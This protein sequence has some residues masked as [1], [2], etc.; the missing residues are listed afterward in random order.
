MKIF[1][2]A[3]LAAAVTAIKLGE[4]ELPDDLAEDLKADLGITDADLE[5]LEKLPPKDKKKMIKEAAKAAGAEGLGDDLID[6]MG[7]TELADE[8]GDK[9]EKPKKKGPPPPKDG[10]GEGDMPP[11]CDEGDE[12][13]MAEV[14]ELKKMLAEEGIC[15]EDDDSCFGDALIMLDE[16]MGDDELAQKPPKGEMSGSEG[17]FDG[18]SDDGEE[19]AQKPPK[20]EMSGSEGPSSDSDAESSESEA[21]L[22]QKGPKPPKGEDGDGPESEGGESEGSFSGTESEGEELA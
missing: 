5:A 13:C 14:G 4:D 12:E 8:G 1:Q 3:L 19:L 15:S 6:K 22:A 21:E 20:G 11:L 10:E 17:S 7:L 16:E 2:A 9:A 18:S